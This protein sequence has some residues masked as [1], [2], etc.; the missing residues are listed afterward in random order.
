MFFVINTENYNFSNIPILSG[1]DIIQRGIVFYIY[2]NITYTIVSYFA[3]IL[4]DSYSRILVLQ[5]GFF[6][7][8]IS[9][10]VFIVSN[11]F[12]SLVF[13]FT[14]FGVGYGFNEGNIR[15]VFA[16]QIEKKYKATAYGIFHG[17]LGISLFFGNITA[18]LLYKVDSDLSFTFA[19]VFSF[20]AFGYLLLSSKK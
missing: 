12:I 2:F 6:I 20:F 9:L 10:L 1:L 3:G 17:V 5:I 15:A 4:A 7:Y 11:G 8:F 14:L 16:D 13:A 18:G 19:G